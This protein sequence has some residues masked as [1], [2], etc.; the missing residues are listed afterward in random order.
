M[1]VTCSQ[2]GKVLCGQIETVVS[3]LSKMMSCAWSLHFTVDA[4]CS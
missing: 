4:A 3:I 1:E 2:M